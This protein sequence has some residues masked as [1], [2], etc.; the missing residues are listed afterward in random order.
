ML[1]YAR[2]VVIDQGN[3]VFTKGIDCLLFWNAGGCGDGKL[4]AGLFLALFSLRMWQAN[5]GQ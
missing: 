1:G 2:V 3:A 4:T 5:N